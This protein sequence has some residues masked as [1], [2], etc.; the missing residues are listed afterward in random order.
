MDLMI[1]QL[2]TF[3]YFDPGSGSLVMQALIGGTAGLFVL[4]KY[5]WTAAPTLFLGK[6]TPD[7]T[8]DHSTSV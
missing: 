2:P 6:K 3:A 5:V 8:K 4:A 1:S 7:S